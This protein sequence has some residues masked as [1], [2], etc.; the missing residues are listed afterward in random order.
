MARMLVFAVPS[1]D[2]KLQ[3]SGF[4]ES[5]GYGFKVRM[6]LSSPDN[7]NAHHSKTAA[8]EMQRRG[9]ICR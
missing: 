5:E 2:S 9:M 7:A 1:C 6:Q 4:R 8:D 3:I